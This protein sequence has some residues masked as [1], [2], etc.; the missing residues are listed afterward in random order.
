MKRCLAPFSNC[1]PAPRNL[2]YLGP[3]FTPK[4]VMLVPDSDADGLV[5][6]EPESNVSAGDVLPFIPFPARG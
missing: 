4:S 5:V 6:V 2:F 3:T 1:P